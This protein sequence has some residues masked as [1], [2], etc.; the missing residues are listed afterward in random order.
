[1]SPVD[2]VVLVLA[3]AA[4]AC[5]LGILV[6]A[7]VNALTFPRLRGAPASATPAPAE[8]DRPRVSVLIPARDEAPV[9]AR[10][11]DDLRSQTV[12][13]IE[14]VVL[15]DAS[16]DGTGSVAREAAEDDPRVR[17]VLGQPLPPGWTGKPW[18]CAQLA[19]EARAD[20]L[21]FADADTRWAPDALA[22][23]LDERERTDAD[24]LSAW[25]TQE[26]V[27]WAERLTV[28]LIAFTV[29]GYLPA[30]AVHHL[31]Y[32]SMSAAVG[33]CLLFRRESYRAIGG[34]AAVRSAVL[35]D[36]AL[37]RSIKRMGGRLREV[38]AAGLITCR[39][40][41]GWPS[42]RDG[43]AKNMLAGWGGSV[44][45]L[46]AGS[47]FHWLI[48]LLPWIW[49]LAGPLLPASGAVRAG[50]DGWWPVWPLLLAGLGV[51]VRA[52]TAAVTRQRVRDAVLL[53]VSALLFTAIAW[54]S[55]AWARSGGPRWKGRVV[56][57]SDAGPGRTSGGR[58]GP[59]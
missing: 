56:A 51:A 6:I 30:V 11:V 39:M 1:M 26:T 8:D 22:A 4:S 46:V 10:L 43:F 28:P 48:L 9:I 18:A 57:A 20:L 3:I 37:A 53:P 23:L 16:S 32:P 33:Q 47:V 54:R 19:D 5:L 45:G 59:G 49:L 58:P 25:P 40:Y 24:L 42:A 12:A 35:E 14:V 27:S 34:H 7:I 13:G 17:V 2:V 29:H 31:P 44:A 55:A 38:D 41:A 21:L 15:D 36:I 52:L 50:P